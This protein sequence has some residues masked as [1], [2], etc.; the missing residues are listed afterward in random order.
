MKRALIGGFLTLVGTVW[1]LG[2]LLAAAVYVPQV[3]NWW[4]PPGP[5]RHG[6]YGDQYDGAA[7]NWRGHGGVRAGGD[8]IRIF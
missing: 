6:D 1:C 4:N 7:D 5:V 8:D 3:T 2:A